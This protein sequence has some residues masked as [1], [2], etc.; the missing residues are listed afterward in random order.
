MKSINRVE[1]TI[2]L[3]KECVERLA[4]LKE[5]PTRSPIDCELQFNITSIQFSTISCLYVLFHTEIYKKFGYIDLQDLHPTKQNP[6]FDFETEILPFIET[7]L[8]EEQL[9]NSLSVENAIKSMKRF[10]V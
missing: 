9:E 8:L 10:K 6:E 3:Y 2:K 1:G 5:Q 4:N 7:C